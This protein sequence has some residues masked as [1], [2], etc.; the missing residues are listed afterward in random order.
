[1][2]RKLLKQIFSERR[3][4]AWLILELAIISAV[5]WWLTDFAWFCQT[6]RMMPM[7]LDTSNVVRIQLAEYDPSSPLYTE[8]DYGIRTGAQGD[9]LSAN[10][11]ERQMLMKRL[12]ED[13][14]VVAATEANMGSAPYN[15]NFYGNSYIPADTSLHVTLNYSLNNFFV[16]DDY[17]KVFIPTG[18]RGES[19]ERLDEIINDGTKMIVTSNLVQSGMQPEKLYNFELDGGGRIKTIGAVVE[20]VRRAEYEYPW[21]ATAF[22]KQI[23]YYFDCIYVRTKP[24]RMEAFKATLSE[25]DKNLRVNGNVHIT[26]VKDFRQIRDALHRKDDAF[27]RN[28]IIT[29]GFMLLTAFLGVLGTFWFRTQERAREIAVRKVAGAGNATVFRR[30]IGEGI[31]LLTIATVFAV[32]LDCLMVWQGLSMRGQQSGIMWGLSFIEMGVVYLIMAAMVAA[33]ILFPA[34]RAMKIDPATTLRGE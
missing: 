12:R 32:G 1:M 17:F 3:S 20:P 14:D 33:G 28:S 25:M 7:G 29:M 8:R 4:N 10:A 31:M 19:P 2:K 15:Y 9:T 21:H 22:I 13:P 5:M 27:Q 18:L 11:I 26:Q 6:L 30:L 24:G 34:Y 16:G 23:S